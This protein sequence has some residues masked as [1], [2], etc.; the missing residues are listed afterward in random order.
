MRKII[1]FESWQHKFS[2]IAL[3]FLEDIVW[4]IWRIYENQHIAPEV[5]FN[6]PRLMFNNGF[7]GFNLFDYLNVMFLFSYLHCIHNSNM[8]SFVI[9]ITTRRVRF[10]FC[11]IN[12]KVLKDWRIT[13]ADAFLRLWQLQA[14]TAVSAQKKN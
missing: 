1:D 2:I 3:V 8:N 4:V 13:K 12:L 11:K 9:F 7:I 5:K 10:S 14:F 6:T